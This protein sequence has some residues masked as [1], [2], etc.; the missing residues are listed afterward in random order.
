M[1][2]SYALAAQKDSATNLEIAHFSSRIAA[3]THSDSSSMITMAALTMLFLPG[4]FVSAIFS[5]VFFQ[6]TTAGTE[7]C[8]W[9]QA[10]GSSQPQ[11]SRSPFWYSP[12]GIYG[13]AA[14]P[15]RGEC[16]RSARRQRAT[17]HRQPTNPWVQPLPFRG[18][19]SPLQ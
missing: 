15:R 17:G 4:T 19:N 10:G 13:G 16:G 3:E 18:Q 7:R 5:T 11:R 9:R 8:A 14:A 6:T 12:Y 1:N 2:L